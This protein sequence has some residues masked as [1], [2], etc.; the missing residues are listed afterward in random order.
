MELWSDGPG[1][2]Q[3]RQNTKGPK[4]NTMQNTERRQ[5]RCM[6]LAADG[7]YAKATKALIS[8]SP[9]GRDESTELAMREKHPIAQEAPNLSDLAV[10]G[11]G[12]VPE[13][14]SILV[15]KMLK[16]FS[17]GTAPGP[18]GLRAQHLKD[19]V[20]S[21]HGDEALEQI[22]TLCKL[23]ARGDAPELLAQ[24]IAGAS[25]LALQKPGGGVRPIAIGDVL[26]RLVAKCF[27]KIYE[28]EAKTYLW[29]KQIG[30]AAPLG[31]EVG[32]Q[33]V[34]QWCERNQTSEG[35]LIF[36]ADFE[37][38]FN[39]IDRGM[40]LREVRHRMPGLARWVEWCYR[41]PTNL[42]FDGVVIR[43]EVG[44]Q[45]GD[46]LGPL[47]FALAL[48]PV[49]V[50]VGN[51]P[52]LDLSFSYLDDLVLAGEQSVVVVGITLLKNSAVNLGLR[53]NMSKCELVPAVPGGEGINWSLFDQNMPRKL[54]GCF[55]LLGAPIG[56]KEYAQSLTNKRAT[57]IQSCLDAIGELPDPQVALALL[58][59][60]ASFGKMVF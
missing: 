41:R 56:S 57:K 22:T 30:V 38:A 3:G 46:P 7:Q 16:T 44:V 26:R 48:Q 19:A 14:D 25:L 43:S 1:A 6:E 8:P 28:E 24:H 10:P 13:L 52:G 5:Q 60:C 4:P 17:R 12:Q 47:L 53:L 59:S 33:T 55:K 18:T 9:L 20:R 32:S 31:A 29:P 49:L 50:E 45:Q 42:Y 51:I 40:F 54:D 21:P 35:K 2:R 37:N 58:R 27:C 36:V 15:N 39:T 23:L 11:R 34:R